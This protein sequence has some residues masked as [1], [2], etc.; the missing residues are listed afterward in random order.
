[1]PITTIIP[2]EELRNAIAR[3]VKEVNDGVADMREAG[4]LAEL[5]NEIQFQMEV[6]MK[7]GALEQVNVTTDKSEE[8]QGGKTIESGNRRSTS[9]GSQNSANNRTGVQVHQ[10][11][12]SDTS[13]TETEQ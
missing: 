3:V 5:P 9:N 10:Q 8:A 1:M 2:I 11:N 4:I 6:V 12:T 7:F 13:T